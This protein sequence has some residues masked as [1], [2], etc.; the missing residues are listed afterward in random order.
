[1]DM[2][3]KPGS[4]KSGEGYIFVADV[5]RADQ[6]YPELCTTRQEYESW[7]RTAKLWKTRYERNQRAFDGNLPERAFIVGSPGPS[8]NRIDWKASPEELREIY[9]KRNTW[10]YSEVFERVATHLN[11]ASFD[12]YLQDTL[13]Y[14]LVHSDSA[15]WQSRG[16]GGPAPRLP[17]MIRVYRKPDMYRYHPWYC[18]WP[19]EPYSERH[20]QREKIEPW[21]PYSPE[22]DKVYFERLIQFA[23]ASQKD[24]LRQVMQKICIEL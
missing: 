15:V 19:V 11:P 7:K 22:Y 17:G 13:R 12:S 4:D 14:Q 24:W 3:L 2:W 8:K 16:V 21:S 23:P 9:E 5:M 6:I 1:M 20:A 10:P 18:G